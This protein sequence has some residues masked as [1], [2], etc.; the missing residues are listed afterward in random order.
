[1]LEKTLQSPWDS[2]VIKPVNPK[3][4]QSWIFIG[5]TNAEALILCPPDLKSWLICKDPNAGNDWGQEEK[6]A[7]ENKTDGSTD[8]TDMSLS[9]LQE[10]VKDREVWHVVVHGVAKNQTQLNDWTM[11]MWPSNSTSG[12]LPKKMKILIKKETCS[13]LYTVELFT[14]A[15][16]WKQS[17]CPTTDGYKRCSIY[18]YMYIHSVYV[19]IC[20]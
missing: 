6:G 8:S 2:K 19:C 17:R 3:G 10:L 20:I 15:E 9:K 4:N 5:R 11:A 16:I 13:S 18:T 14:I 1:M 12:Y 7:T